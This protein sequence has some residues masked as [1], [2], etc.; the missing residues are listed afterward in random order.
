MGCLEALDF[1]I[2]VKEES[3]LNS[4]PNLKL[5]QVVHDFIICKFILQAGHLYGF[6]FLERINATS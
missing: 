6:T 5:D 1:N 2:L 3:A 4:D